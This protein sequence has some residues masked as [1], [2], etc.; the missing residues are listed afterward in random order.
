VA[1]KSIL[2]LFLFFLV[3]FTSSAYV[4]A[5]GKLIGTS[6]VSQVEGSAGGGLVPWA[7]LAGYS[8]RDEQGAAAFFSAVTVDNFR[9]VSHGF[10]YAYHDRIEASFAHQKFESDDKSIRLSQDILGFK[11]RIFGDLV[12]SLWPQ[13]ALGLQYKNA[14]NSKLLKSIGSRDDK[15]VDY[16]LA[17]TKA[18]LD[19]PFHRNF[20]LNTTLRYTKGNQLGLQGFGGDKHDAYNSLFEASVGLYISRHWVVGVEYRQKPDNLSALKEDDWKDLFIVYVPN[21][22]LSLTTA[23]VDL[24]RLGGLSDQKGAYMSLQLAY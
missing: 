23:F 14:S 19:G 17:A 11:V 5:G 6:G 24:G 4:C 3:S 2:N 13:L 9:M 15:G 12:Y 1:M 16:Y 8:T 22:R 20:V 7:T 18:W 10:S 21:K